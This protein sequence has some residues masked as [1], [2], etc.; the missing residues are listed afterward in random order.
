MTLTLRRGVLLTILAIVLEFS[1]GCSSATARREPQPTHPDEH[2][3]HSDQEHYDR[4][5]A[6][7]PK[8][9]PD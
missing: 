1:A 8:R 3:F 4:A 9:T 2:E 5:G 6:V 7:E